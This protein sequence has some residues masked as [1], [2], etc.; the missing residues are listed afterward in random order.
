VAQYGDLQNS[1]GD[2]VM[3]TPSTP[4]TSAVPATTTASTIPQWG[5]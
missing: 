3:P 5:F 4:Q 1:G 2:A